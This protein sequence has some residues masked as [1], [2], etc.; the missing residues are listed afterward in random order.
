MSTYYFVGFK[1]TSIY[2]FMLNIDKRDS[3]MNTQNIFFTGALI[4]ILR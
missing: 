2:E 3:K 1:M 4:I